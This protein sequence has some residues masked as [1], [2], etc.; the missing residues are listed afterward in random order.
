[1]RKGIAVF[2]LALVLVISFAFGLSSCGSVEFDV[3][4]IVDGESYYE[5]TTAGES[6]I[7]LP[8]DPTKEGYNFTGWYLD[9]GVWEA[10][11][12]ESYFVGKRLTDNISVYAKWNAIEYQINFIVDGESYYE[13]T[14][15]GESVIAL[16]EEP[17]DEEYNFVGWYFDEGVW[18]AELTES[19]FVGTRLT[20]NISV[21]A[22][23]VEKPHVHTVVDGA[24]AEC[25][26]PES[27]AGLAFSLN[28]D[29]YGYTLTGKGECS[30]SSIVVGI[31]NG[32][33]VT[34]IA[35]YAF[36]YVAR[37]KSVKL[38]ECVT[39]IGNYAFAG[40]NVEIISLHNKI[41]S[42]GEGAFLGT[43]LLYCNYGYMKYLGTM[44]APYMI[45][46]GSANSEYHPYTVDIPASTRIICS[47][48]FDNNNGKLTGEFR[49]SEENEHFMAKDN[50][51][52]TKDGKTL[53]KYA[54]GNYN[55]KSFA[56]PDGV[57]KIAEKAFYQVQRLGNV[58][59]PASVTEIGRYAFGGADYIESIEVDS[60][61]P[62]YKSIDG[63]LYTKDGK[64][65]V[66]Y[67]NDMDEKSFIV[68]NGVTEIADGAFYYARLLRNV[69][70][71]ESVTEIGVNAFY[72]CYGLTITFKDKT[73]WERDGESVS[74]E[75]L[76]DIAFLK[77][78][79]C[80]TA[81]YPY[82]KWVKTKNTDT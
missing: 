27:S 24:C 51:L 21:Y 66:Q 13:I 26:I 2:L 75:S 68:P 37:L 39:D 70:I 16:P 55:L 34:A 64:T 29:G 12:T 32:L 81:R 59:I 58:T 54:V 41:E 73:G 53:I 57:T 52:Y 78:T 62:V 47:D 49:V 14:T 40:S 17:T 79:L 30:E 77:D 43:N 46:V 19:H 11:I 6:D 9:E 10:E 23:W 5:I 1:M 82:K 48:A 42:V 15:A 18:E 36:E 45:L 76:D 31:Y 22:K 28:P 60:E 69:I 74:P 33:S 35:D 8:E 20:E 72:G 38:Y 80:G 25:C 50:V 7:V 56:I 3:N 4:F 71:P 65:L 67:V 44:E 63:N 61:N